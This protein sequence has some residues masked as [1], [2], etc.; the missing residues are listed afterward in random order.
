MT[1]N[2][3]V[4]HHAGIWNLHCHRL[5]LNSDACL[6]FLELKACTTLSGSELF[7]ATIPQDL[8]VKN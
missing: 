5:A 2:K 3:D 4:Y 6:G 7:L 8:H 1:Q